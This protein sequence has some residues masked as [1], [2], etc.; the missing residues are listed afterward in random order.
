MTD[1][2]H[3]MQ[4][5]SKIQLIQP[6]HD[7]NN[8]IN[9]TPSEDSDQPGHPPSLIRVFAVRM[10]KVLGSLATHLAHSEDW[11]DW[12][13]AHADLSVCW[14][15]V[16]LLVLLCFGSMINVITAT[17]WARRCIYKMFIVCRNSRITN[18]QLLSQP[19]TAISTVGPCSCMFHHTIL[20]FV[21][22][23]LAVGAWWESHLVIL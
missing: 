21:W 19:T 6:Q 7:K 8:K 17:F 4:E 5:L 13:D 11:S 16:I 2:Y 18:K 3:G 12:V 9:C 10:K 15:H 1:T 14:V 23:L 20:S 22:S